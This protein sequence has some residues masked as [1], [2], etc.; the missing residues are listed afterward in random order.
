MMLML[1]LLILALAVVALLS[2]ATAKVQE[3]EKGLLSPAQVLE[4]TGTASLTYY[5]SYPF[6]CPE[7]PNYDPNFPE[8]E[9]SDF[10]G[11]QDMGNFAAFQQD[12]NPDGHVCLEYVQTHNLVAFYDNSDPEGNNWA[13]KF[14]NKDIQITKIYNGITYVFDAT[15]ADTCVNQD[16]NDCCSTN[17]QP[18]GFLVDIEYYTALNVFGSLDAVDGEVS[19]VVL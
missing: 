10:S 7:S 13:S 4:T 9:C 18:S 3:Q 16:C 5:M 19:F 14:A 11:C 1:L 17:S 6:C 2:P 8:E 15:V 12:S